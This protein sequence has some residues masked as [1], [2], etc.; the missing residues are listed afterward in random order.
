MINTYDLKISQPQKFNQLSVK[1]MLFVYY[2][3]PQVEK[4]LELFTHL[5]EIAFTLSGKKTIQQGGKS[6]V[7]TENK[8][9]FLR[10]AAYKQELDETSG[11]EVLAF[12]FND[13]FLRKVFD[14]YRLYLPLN[15]LPNPPKEM[16]IEITV[17]ETARAFFFSIIPYFDKKNPPPEKLLE[18]KFKELIFT[19][20]A[21]PSNARLLAY[22]NSIQNQFKTPIWEVMETNYTFN[23]TIDEFAKIAQRSPATF[24]REFR[25]YYHTTPG[26]W[27]TKRKLEHAK[28]VLETSDRL[29]KEVAIESG[30][31]N[32]SHFSRVFKKTYGV[33]PSAYRQNNHK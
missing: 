27:L 4:Q 24:K 31:E 9:L 1:D 16:F 10:R 19:I 22:V 14:E 8:S 17:N 11:W 3:C 15:N 12:Y 6:W 7:L 25:E 5:N 18:H 30:F 2:H 23:L 26:K 33:T 13:D 29:V 20:L 28:L 21:D 32:L